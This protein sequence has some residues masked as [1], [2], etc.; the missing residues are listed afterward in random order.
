MS[1]IKGTKPAHFGVWKAFCARREGCIRDTMQGRAM[2]EGRAKRKTDMAGRE[3]ENRSGMTWNPVTGCTKVSPACKN[4]YAEPIARRL[5]KQGAPGYANGF[6]LTLH[7]SRLDQ[8]KRRKKPSFYFAN[9][10]S[11]LF[12]DGVPDDFLDA[13]MAVMHAT[14]QHT[15]MVLTKRAGRLPAYFGERPCPS[16]LWLGV[17]VED[18]AHGIPRMDLLRRVDAPLRLVNMEPLLEDPGKLDLS[19]IGWVMA[20]GETGPD[21]RPMKREWLA[22]VRD[23]A[24]AAGV[25]FCFSK[26]GEWGED[27]VRRGRQ[28]TGRLLDGRIWDERPSY[29]GIAP[30]ESR[31]EPAQFTLGF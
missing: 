3:K 8:P 29:N 19:G 25:P 30:D 31:E 27:G 2:R 24:V 13:V 1:G 7:S 12:H 23:Q 5:Q 22:S 14:P 26:W 18:R 10:M 16:N 6:A 15:Y 11:D 17:T 4:C 21:A 28:A 9:S 20:G